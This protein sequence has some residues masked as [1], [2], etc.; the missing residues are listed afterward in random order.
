[1]PESAVSGPTVVVVGSVHMDLVATADRLPARGETLPGRTLT[2][3]PGGKGGNQAVQVSL[4]GARSVMLGRVGGDAFGAQLRA[5]LVGKGVVLDWLEEDAE[6]ST[7][8]STVLVGEGGDYCSVIVPGASLALTPERVD[9]ALPCFAA[10][11][12]VVAQLELS[13]ETVKAALARGRAAGAITVLNAA[14]AP[15]VADALDLVL[16]LVDVLVVNEVEARM[17]SGNPPHL[18]EAIEELRR[19]FLAGGRHRGLVVTLGAAGALI[20]FG[21]RRERLRAHSVHAIDAIGAGDA[22]VGTMAASLAL[23]ARLDAA[24]RRGNAAGALAATV[25]GA[26]D[27][28]PTSAAVDAFL[29]STQTDER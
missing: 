5:A 7:G 11:R 28:F 13:I 23:G 3:H 17:L 8:A 24:A 9:A 14:P 20:E 15:S 2:I 16:S 18:G 25:A 10:A 29:G 6:L 26:Y 1:M 19:R 27:A 4:A 21:G 12:V 22:F